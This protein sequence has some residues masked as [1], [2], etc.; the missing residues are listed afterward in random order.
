METFIDQIFAMVDGSP[1]DEGRI[2]EAFPS[3]DVTLL[4]KEIMAWAL[5]ENNPDG[6]ECSAIVGFAV[7]FAG[8]EE[9]LIEAMGADWHRRHEEI[10]HIMGSLGLSSHVEAMVE[11][12][13]D[14]PP[15]A[16]SNPD[17]PVL[18]QIVYEISNIR[19]DESVEALKH[20]SRK[21]PYEVVV[22]AALARL[23][24]LGAA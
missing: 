17:Y 11:R 6:L 10:G 13:L 2:R 15:Y 14:P 21:S 16:L 18:C 8:C 5:L 19:N 7:G 12:I 22:K 20:I 9:I 24:D 4:A 1:L 23:K 3:Y